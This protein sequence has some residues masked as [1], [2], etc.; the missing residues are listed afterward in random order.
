VLPNIKGINQKNGG[1]S[2]VFLIRNYEDGLK[3]YNSAKTKNALTCVIAG[4]GLIGLEMVEAFKKR[5]G[6]RKMDTT[7]VEM[8]DHILPT[9]LDKIWQKL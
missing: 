1:S 5:S 7:V 6:R 4:A 2:S 3:I 9:L 8:S